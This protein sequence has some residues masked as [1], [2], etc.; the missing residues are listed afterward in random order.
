VCDSNHESLRLL[1]P[2][3]RLGPDP[4]PEP[5]ENPFPP[6]PASGYESTSR[7]PPPPHLARIPAPPAASLFA[8]TVLLAFYPN[9]SQ[10]CWHSGPHDFFRLL[11]LNASPLPDVYRRQAVP[12][13]MLQI[14]HAYPRRIRPSSVLECF[15]RFFAVQHS[16]RD[17]RRGSFL[18]TSFFSG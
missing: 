6:L 4:S 5:D 16:T 3:C 17:E 11:A 18:A 7:R 10:R 13:D 12:C 1:P 2:R 14:V 8:R 15:L 9:S